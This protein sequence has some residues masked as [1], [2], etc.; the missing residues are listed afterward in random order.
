MI[1]I[2]NKKKSHEILQYI[3]EQKKKKQKMKVDEPIFPENN[4]LNNNTRGSGFIYED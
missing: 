3:A 1:E 4:S 2:N